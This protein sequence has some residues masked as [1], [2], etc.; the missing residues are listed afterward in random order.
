MERPRGCAIIFF[1]G[2]GEI[3]LLLRDDIPTIPW[4]GMWDIPGGHVEPGETPEE[5][6]V[7]EMKEEMGLELADFSLFR[8]VDFP[9]RTEFVFKKP[10]E[11]D[12]NRVCLTEGQCIRWFSREE[13]LSLDLA[14]HFSRVVE[15]F[16]RVCL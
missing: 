6:I 13:A 4:P 16:F 14:C 11:L 10:M 15:A 8:R 9:D 3:L 1:N 2:R 5:C 12:V 7:R